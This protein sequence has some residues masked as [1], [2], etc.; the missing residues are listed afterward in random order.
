M[1]IAEAIECRRGRHPVGPGPR[2]PSKQ[3]E[4]EAEETR[5]RGEDPGI[6]PGPARKDEW[7]SDRVGAAPGLVGNG[8][9]GPLLNAGEVVVQASAPPS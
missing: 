2:R 4:A 9:Q 3:G 7:I 1:T 6:A 8:R 5:F